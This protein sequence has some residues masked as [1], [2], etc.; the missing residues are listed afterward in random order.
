TSMAAA[1]V[2]GA[3]ALLL[4]ERPNLKPLGVKIA[5]QMSASMMSNYGLVRAGTGSLNVLAAAEFV[6]DGNLDDTT[7][8]G[9]EAD[10]SHFALAPGAHLVSAQSALE[11]A[12]PLPRVSGPRNAA[13]RT[14]VNQA[15]RKTGRV[16]GA[17]DALVWGASNALVWA[18]SDA[19]VW[20]AS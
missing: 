11:N 14:K 3:A 18:A 2:S 19:L 16:K 10:A 9:Q 7:I 13:T 17:S 6:R 4:E 5:L 20:G 15:L 1:F 8:S 12:I